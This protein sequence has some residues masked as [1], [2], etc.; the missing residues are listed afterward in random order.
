MKRS[1]RFAALGLL[2]AAALSSTN[3]QIARKATSP[4]E[5]FGFNIGA[6]DHVADYTQLEAYWKK[7]LKDGT[8]VVEAKVGEGKVFVMGPEMT[9]R[10]A[11]HATFKFL[12][13]GVL[14]GGAKSA[15]LQ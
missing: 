13:N 2:L 5:A 14:Y 11:T 1:S 4:L 10:G 6:D 3:A 8:A 15:T 12:F 9:F 7:Y